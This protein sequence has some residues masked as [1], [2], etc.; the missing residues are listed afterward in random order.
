MIS[1]RLG[2]E[3]LVV[4][5]LLHGLD[6][7]EVSTFRLHADLEQRQPDR[8][9]RRGQ[10]YMEPPVCPSTLCRCEGGF[11]CINEFCEMA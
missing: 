10:F 3:L 8:L 9:A 4:P 2:V 7:K 5:R 1:H 11:Q 6:P